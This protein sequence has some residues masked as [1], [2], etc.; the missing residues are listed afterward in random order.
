MQC[1]NSNPLEQETNQ[2]LYIS[3]LRFSIKICLRKSEG[4]VERIS[5]FNVNEKLA[6]QWH[7][8]FA[9]LRNL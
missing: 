3:I 1:K 6:G 4:S 2:S 8:L 7:T 9:M 5:V